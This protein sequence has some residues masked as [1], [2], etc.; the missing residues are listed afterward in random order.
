MIWNI[1]LFYLIF[2]LSEPGFSGFS[3]FQINGMNAFWHSPGL[4]SDA[5][6]FHSK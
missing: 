5:V 2:P 4:E 1:R 3:D 6:E